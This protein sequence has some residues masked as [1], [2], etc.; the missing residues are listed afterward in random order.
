LKKKDIKAI[1]EKLS[2][3][4]AFHINLVNK[5]DQRLIGGIQVVVANQIFDL[6]I[7]GQLDKLKLATIANKI[8]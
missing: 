8:K 1:E 4:F 5:I 7:Q 2:K 3:K 6:S